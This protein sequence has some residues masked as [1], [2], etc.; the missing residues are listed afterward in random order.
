MIA[1]TK[2]PFAR[3]LGGILRGVTT[4]GA[5][6]M[7]LISGCTRHTVRVEP[8]EVKPIHVTMDINLRVQKELDRFF[9]WEDEVTPQSKSSN[10]ADATSKSSSTD[11]DA[12][13][14]KPQP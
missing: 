5:V 10:G 14:S 9:E 13:D 12:T 3:D 6:A 7:I 1:V 11:S 8:V 4:V 2:R